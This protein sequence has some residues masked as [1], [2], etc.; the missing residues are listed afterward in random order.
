ML[1]PLSEHPLDMLR[2]KDD[3]PLCG[4]LLVNMF[5]LLRSSFASSVMKSQIYISFSIFVIT[6]ISITHETQKRLA[7]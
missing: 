5:F 7:V 6:I 2:E 4:L 1:I 3:D